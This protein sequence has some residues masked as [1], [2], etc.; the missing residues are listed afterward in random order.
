M[1]EQAVK[2]V[3]QFVRDER[4]AVPEPLRNLQVKYVQ[5]L[6]DSSEFIDYIDALGELDGRSALLEWKTT[7]ARYPEQP[8]GLYSLDQ[9]LVAYSWI[10]GIAEVVMVVSSTRRV[11]RSSTWRS[12]SPSSNARNT[13]PW[14]GIDPADRVRALPPSH[15]GPLPA[16]RMR[17]VRL[18]G[19]MPRSAGAGRYPTGTSAGRKPD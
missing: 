18:P 17:D 14:L 3:E 5:R 12:P 1:A 16:E 8:A 2:L 9:Q 19:T 13:P 7:G 15:R 11:S 6:S 4:I 10:P